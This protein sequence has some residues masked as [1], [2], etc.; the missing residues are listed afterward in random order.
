MTRPGLVVAIAILLS[1]PMAPGVLDGA[2]SAET[3]LLRFLVALL[4]C[5]G[6]SALVGGVLRRYSEQ[7]RRAHVLRI[8]EEARQRTSH[9]TAPAP[10]TGTGPMGSGATAVPGSKGATP[11]TGPPGAD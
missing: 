8:I 6:S 2:I 11:A 4:L 7:S 10:G 5:W 1:L 3:A 9:G